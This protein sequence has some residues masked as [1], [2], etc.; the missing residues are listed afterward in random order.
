MSVSVTFRN[1]DQTTISA[2]KFFCN[3]NELS[4]K[5]EVMEAFSNKDNLIKIQGWVY[6]IEFYVYNIIGFTI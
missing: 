1:G 3:G 6:D 4:S 5:D 2:T